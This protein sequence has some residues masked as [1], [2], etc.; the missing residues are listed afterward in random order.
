M[1][2]ELI[3]ELGGWRSL[4]AGFIILSFLGFAGLLA[5]SGHSPHLYVAIAYLLLAASILASVSP[6]ASASESEKGFDPDAGFRLDLDLEPDWEDCDCCGST[7][8]YNDKVGQ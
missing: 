4:A 5:V 1:T 8:T 2:T 7:S 3:D 6:R